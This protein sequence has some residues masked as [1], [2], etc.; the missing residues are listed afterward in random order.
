MADPRTILLEPL[1]NALP[2]PYGKSTQELDAM[3]G[4]YRQELDQYDDKTLGAVRADVLRHSPKWPALADL[5]EKCNKERGKQAAAR[6]P[7]HKMTQAELFMSPAGQY[8]LEHKF[9]HNMWI[10]VEEH[11]IVDIHEAKAM[12]AK[13]ERDREEFDMEKELAGVKSAGLKSTLRNAYENMGQNENRLQAEH[14]RMN[15]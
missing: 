11:G 5:I 3:L 4:L 2:K 8:A 10:H 14:G 13:W 15:E 9:A 12:V 6:P 7:P 1:F